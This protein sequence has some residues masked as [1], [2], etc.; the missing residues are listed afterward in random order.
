MHRYVGCCHNLNNASSSSLAYR[1][2]QINAALDLV[3]DHHRLHGVV[4]FADEEG[5]YSLRLFH[6]LRQIRYALLH[7][8]PFNPPA[9][10]RFRQKKK[11]PIW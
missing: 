2:H 8:I 10:T 4:Y 1:P 3:E 7:S 5:V 11:K 9:P 6:R